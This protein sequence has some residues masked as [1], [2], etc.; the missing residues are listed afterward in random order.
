MW[1]QKA[2]GAKKET[3]IKPIHW[4]LDYCSRLI[5][6]NAAQYVHCNFA[7]LIECKT[8]QTK[9]DK[10]PCNWIW[11]FFSF[12][13]VSLLTL[14]FSNQINENK[15]T[16]FNKT[17][18]FFFTRRDRY[19]T[20]LYLFECTITL[21]WRSSSDPSMQPVS[22][23]DGNLSRVSQDIV[24]E[25]IRSYHLRTR[26][27]WCREK[28]SKICRNSDQDRE[29]Q[30]FFP[31]TAVCMFVILKIVVVEHSMSKTIIF[32]NCGM[33]PNIFPSRYNN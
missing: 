24:S 26:S 2:R 13:L 22:E 6:L 33:E 18:T 1:K 30:N 12:S 14:D 21:Y 27:S 20:L 8:K 17:K 32:G 28:L 11:L 5:Y 10:P 15:T 31:H 7:K 19:A 23:S 16:V 29:S 4:Q 3:K 9:T 25:D